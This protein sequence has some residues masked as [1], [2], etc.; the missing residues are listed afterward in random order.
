MPGRRERGE[1]KRETNIDLTPKQLGKNA[2]K[3]WE[4]RKTWQKFPL[5]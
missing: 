3:Q 4:M 5:S 2:G 1:E